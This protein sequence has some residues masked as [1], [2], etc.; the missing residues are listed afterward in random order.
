MHAE[1][2]IFDIEVLLLAGFF[3]IPVKEIPIGWQEVDGTKMQLA[4]DSVLM[5]KDLVIIRLNY[6]IGRWRVK[7]VPEFNVPPQ[8]TQT[9]EPQQRRRSARKKV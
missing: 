8:E 3:N 9:E 1:G 4:R 6:L 2:W 5:L 7:R